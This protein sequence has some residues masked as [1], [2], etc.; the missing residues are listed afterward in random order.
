MVDIAR[1]SDVIKKK[2]IRRILYAVGGLGVAVAW[3]PLVRPVGRLA[4]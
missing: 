4:V 1:S 3:R 2:K